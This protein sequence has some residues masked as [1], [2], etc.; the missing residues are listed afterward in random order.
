MGCEAPFA[1]SHQNPA[2]SRPPVSARP[3]HTKIEP[4]AV[5]RVCKRGEHKRPT[6]MKDFS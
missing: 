6:S 2:G 3:L 5:R 1:H 4:R